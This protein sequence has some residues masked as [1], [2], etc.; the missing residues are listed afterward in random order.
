MKTGKISIARAENV[1]A[2]FHVVAIN[3][4]LST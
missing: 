3:T 2:F 1:L 4:N